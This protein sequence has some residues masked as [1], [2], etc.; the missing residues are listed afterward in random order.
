[1]IPQAPTLRARGYILIESLVSLL[2]LSLVLGATLT[3][4]AA[5]AH[6]HRAAL[7]TRRALVVARSQLADVGVDIPAVPGSVNS[8]SGGVAWRVDITAVGSAGRLG[9][10]ARITVAAGLPGERPRVTL[11]ELRL[12]A[13][14]R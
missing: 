1:M 13:P 14:V 7:E 9:T 10:L 2:I 11:S 3:A 6:R 4:V 5:S 8:M 12:L